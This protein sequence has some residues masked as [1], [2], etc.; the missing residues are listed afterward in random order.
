MFHVF[1]IFLFQ[2]QSI[3]FAYIEPSVSGV[4]LEHVDHVVQRDERVVD[5]H[6]LGALGNG[7][8]QNQATDAA[9]TVDA[10]LN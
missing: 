7:R 10:D 5:C 1:M 4:I 6:D 2:N 8:T 9:K 3:L